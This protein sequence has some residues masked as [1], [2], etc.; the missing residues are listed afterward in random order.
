MVKTKRNLDEAMRMWQGD[1]LP[2][3]DVSIEAVYYYFE[4]LFR[5]HR[6]DDYPDGAVHMSDILA[7]MKLLLW[8]SEQDGGD[9]NEVIEKVLDQIDR[10][11][12]AKHKPGG[13]TQ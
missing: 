7:T 5:G 13:G 1:V 10:I 8:L 12:Y 2:S 11:V 4:W 6:P 3:E 9:K